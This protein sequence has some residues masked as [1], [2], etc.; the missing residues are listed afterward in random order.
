MEYKGIKFYKMQENE[1]LTKEYFFDSTFTS[2]VMKKIP[3]N[4]TYIR[5]NVKL[6]TPLNVSA[7]IMF[8][9]L[10]TLKILYEL[11]PDIFNENI[12]SF[13]MQ[14]NSYKIVEFLLSKDIICNSLF[15]YKAL[16]FCRQ[17][18]FNDIYQ[19]LMNSKENIECQKCLLLN[20]VSNLFKIDFSK[21]E[22]IEDI[23]NRIRT[24]NQILEKL[25]DDYKEYSSQKDNIIHTCEYY[26]EKDYVNKLGYIKYC[27][28]H[29]E[30]RK[31]IKCPICDSSV[32]SC[33]SYTDSE[34]ETNSCSSACSYTC[35]KCEKE[36]QKNDCSVPRYC[37][38]YSPECEKCNKNKV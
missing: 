27:E 13:A 5:D 19:L 15:I 28:A 14:C 20:N 34:S 21:I 31:D 22:N 4:E 9:D 38:T 32:G 18:G 1:F 10:D 2:M 36:E 17:S 16:E 12:I 24:V 6:I 8:E 35:E 23:N 33:T 30:L 11:R 37:T 29:N 3:Y 25:C 26:S 7:V